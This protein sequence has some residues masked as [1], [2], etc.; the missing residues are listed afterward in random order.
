MLRL[1][2]STKKLKFFMMIIVIFG[3]LF[4]IKTISEQTVL[5]SSKEHSNC[6]AGS[7]EPIGIEIIGETA[8]VDEPRIICTNEN[9]IFLTWKE[10]QTSF[11]ATFVVYD[12]DE[13]VYIQELNLDGSFKDESV[14]LYTK[15][16]LL[17]GVT[18]TSDVSFIVDSEYNLHFLWYLMYTNGSS[19][20]DQYDYLY[21]KKLDKNLETLV[22]TKIIFSKKILSG[23]S[24]SP[25]A[26]SYI[27]SLVVDEF[28]NIHFLFNSIYYFYL[29]NDG[30][31]IDYFRLSNSSDSLVIDNLNNTYVTSIKS[32][33]S[34][35]LTKFSFNDG[36]I[37]QIFNKK[38]YYN[39]TKFLT[40]SVIHLFESKLYL[41][42]LQDHVY[43]YYEI[44]S[45][46]SIIHQVELV[47]RIGTLSRDQSLVYNFPIL[48]DYYTHEDQEFQY[49]KYDVNGT[50]IY[51][52]GPILIIASNSSY[53]YGPD[54]LE[55][56]CIVDMN[57]DLWLTWFVNDGNNGFQVMY[58]KISDIGISLIPVTTISP[59][60]HVNDFVIIPELPQSSNIILV[61]L[62]ISLL[63]IFPAMNH[64]RKKSKIIR[65]L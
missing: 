9:R 15:T 49:R 37:S 48:G 45:T 20:G 1:L 7:T 54:I 27:D 16:D 50:I 10:T 21:Y 8:N 42:W 43:T 29:D 57:N 24:S 5:V 34:I 33:D 28:S 30:N 18:A 46:G 56:Q 6:F 17:P 36:N 14:L 40:D 62:I 63:I 11:N 58:W 19:V 44:N 4:S 59:I 31:A 47:L 26:S 12:F 25:F 39:D 3:S 53:F 38:I 52:A 32:Y 41:S 65:K 61:T 64:K 22:D 35:Y 13:T 51:D 2:K 23:F 60:Y 55:F